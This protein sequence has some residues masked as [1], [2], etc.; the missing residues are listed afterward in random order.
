MK[1]AMKAYADPLLRLGVVKSILTYDVETA[2]WGRALELL[3]AESG[4][5]K[6]Q[7]QETMQAAQLMLNLWLTLHAGGT[8][9]SAERPGREQVKHPDKEHYCRAGS[10]L[11]MCSAPAAGQRSLRAHNH[12]SR[13]MVQLMAEQ[14]GV[15][16]RGSPR[17]SNRKGS[18]NWV[19][20]PS[21]WQVGPSARTA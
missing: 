9:D 17:L 2:Q 21:D 8:A 7:P 15:M 3:L 14:D 10:A 6:G 12:S 16:D 18:V 19:G 11:L 5:V 13:W 4:R 1:E 20:G